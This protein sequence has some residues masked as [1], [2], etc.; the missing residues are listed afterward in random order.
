MMDA[1]A[2]LMFDTFLLPEQ[3]LF[4]LYM[5]VHIN[6]PFCRCLSS[7]LLLYLWL[8]CRFGLDRCFVF[9]MT[10][11]WSPGFSD[12]FFFSWLYPSLGLVSAHGSKEQFCGGNGH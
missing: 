3:Q 6:C 10:V 9:E 4:L 5:L 1:R 7:L 12:C 2:F 8:T 11:D